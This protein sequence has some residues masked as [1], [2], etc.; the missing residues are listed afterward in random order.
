MCLKLELKSVPKNSSKTHT[1]NQTIITVPPTH[2]YT[3]AHAL[4]INR[5]IIWPIHVQLW[6]VDHRFIK[7]TICNKKRE[8]TTEKSALQF[9]N[10]PTVLHY[11]KWRRGRP[12]AVMHT[13][14]HIHT[15]A[16]CRWQPGPG[17][18]SDTLRRMEPPPA[19]H[20]PLKVDPWNGVVVSL[21]K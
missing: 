4:L 5:F 14:T 12:A 10:R 19:H 21:A 16:I 3:S 13:F 17:F 1:I 20:H 8:Q 2:S 18:V 9:F 15:G 7:Q 11:S 6:P